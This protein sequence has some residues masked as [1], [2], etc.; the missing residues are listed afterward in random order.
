MVSVKLKINKYDKATKALCRTILSRFSTYDVAVAEKVCIP[1]KLSIW[2]K[3]QIIWAFFKRRTIVLQQ[4]Y[5]INSVKESIMY[6]E[7]IAV[8]N[9]L[10]VSV[11]LTNYKVPSK[12]P[13]KH[14]KK[15]Q[16]VENSTLEIYVKR[17]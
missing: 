8:L 4:V 11:K 13:K 9:A 2:V 15:L 10:G 17:N 1:K 6:I 5:D 3:L 14:Y 16:L 12:L 7:G